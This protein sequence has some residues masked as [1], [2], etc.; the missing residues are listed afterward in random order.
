MRT[1]TAPTRPARSP[2][3]PAWPAPADPTSF[4]VTS[5]ATITATKTVTGTFNPGGAVTYTVVLL[6][7]G[8]GRADRQSGRRVHRH[9]AGQSDPGQ[10]HRHERDRG[11]DGG[12]NT[13]T[14]NGSLANGASVTITITATIVGVDRA[15]ARRCRIRARPVSMRTAT[16]PTR[17]PLSP[18]IPA[19][20]GAATRPASPSPLRRPCGDQ[21]GDRHVQSWRCRS[22]T[23]SS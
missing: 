5:P 15:R 2:T 9:P 17:P 23:R 8:T 18:T 11:G 12:T 3:I 22:P 14:W 10:R 7:R 20:G 16:A 13:V 6:Q 4:T 1:A 19:A 21:D